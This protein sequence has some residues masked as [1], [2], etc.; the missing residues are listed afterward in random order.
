MFTV[1][2]IQGK[3][4]ELFGHQIFRISSSSMEPKLKVGD[5]ILSKRV[6]DITQLKVDDVITYNGEVGSYAGKT[7]THAVAVEPYKFGDFYYLQ[8]YGIANGYNDPEICETQVVGIMIR[9]MP[10][11]AALY[12]FFTTPLGL[13]VILGFLTLLFV[14]ESITLFGLFKKKKQIVAEDKKAKRNKKNSVNE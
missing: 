1:T 5:I 9:E 13:V 6:K 11:L 3:T 8:T 10:F 12:N 14:N 4:P 2:R 7:I